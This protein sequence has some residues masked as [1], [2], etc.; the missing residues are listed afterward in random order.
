MAERTVTEKD[1]GSVRV[2]R[3]PTPRS[4]KLTATRKR[5]LLAAIAAG[6][7]LTGAAKLAGVSAQ[8]VTNERRRDPEF[9]RQVDE[10]QDGFAE[11]LET[12]AYRRAVTGV[13]RKVYWKGEYC[14]DEIVYA[15]RL[16]ETML[17]ARHP[18][19]KRDDSTKVQ[20]AVVPLT[21]A[22]L[23]GLRDLGRDQLEV[24]EAA[25]LELAPAEREADEKRQAGAGG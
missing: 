18:K 3:P 21:T 17:R 6:N 7:T 8:T 12:E 1:D 23:E 16:L 9:D 5:K 15:D 10:A 22:Q 4:R 11:H 24:L 2:N 20:V 14:G 19:Y 25:A 13:Q